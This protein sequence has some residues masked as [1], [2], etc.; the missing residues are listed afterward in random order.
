MQK[1]I[2]SNTLVIWQH[3][4]NLSHVPPTDPVDWITQE[5]GLENEMKNKL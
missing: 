1:N 3:F 5:A 2:N 4:F